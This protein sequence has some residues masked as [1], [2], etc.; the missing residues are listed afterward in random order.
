MVG[1]GQNFQ[2][3]AGVIPWSMGSYHIVNTTLVNGTL[4]PA[5]L[6]ALKAKSYSLQAENRYGIKG[7][8][9]LELVVHGGKNQKGWE[10]STGYETSGVHQSWKVG[11]GYG[12]R[13][14]QALTIGG[15]WQL[16]SFRLH[17]LQSWLTEIAL[18]FQYKL[19]DNIQWG[20]RYS[21]SGKSNSLSTGFSYR[22]T[23]E[24][25]L[26]AELE[27]KSN[28]PTDGRF[29]LSYQSAA[30]WGFL[31]G[32]EALSNTPFFG[33]SHTAGKQFWRLGLSFHPTLGASMLFGFTHSIP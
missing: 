29:M 30:E 9:L 6:P 28:Q 23:D 2:G 32:A 11:M 7:V 31:L 21:H 19:N 22:F 15:S 20:G 4:L 5:S 33:I 24:L 12:L 1:V 25:H 16:A 18:D 26:T 17:D 27:R 14:S 8:G 3:H 13:L 10:V